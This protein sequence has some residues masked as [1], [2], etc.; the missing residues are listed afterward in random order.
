[1]EHTAQI[2]VDSVIGAQSLTT[3]GKQT[4][5]A[6]IVGTC[7]IG[8][9]WTMNNWLMDKRCTERVSKGTDHGLWSAQAD[10]GLLRCAAC[11]GSPHLC[12]HTE[13]RLRTGLKPRLCEHSSG[14]LL[15][16]PK[17]TQD[18]C[19]ITCSSRYPGFDGLAGSIRIVLHPRL[20]QYMS[21]TLYTATYQG[22]TTGSPYRDLLRA[23]DLPLHECM[24]SI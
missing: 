4:I 24:L 23:D 14:H 13:Q 21:C 9:Q 5:T 7:V 20:G 10:T 19:M 3:I 16:T 22:F 18:A 15:Q 8:A 12:S 6:Q 1:M 11:P 17:A 2:V